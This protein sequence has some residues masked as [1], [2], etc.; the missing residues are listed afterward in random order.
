M[1]IFAS[2]VSRMMLLIFTMFVLSGVA[3]AEK[4]TPP[5]PVLNTMKQMSKFGIKVIN[6]FQG[7][8][9]LTGIVAEVSNP[10]IK[11]PGADKRIIYYI[12]PTGQYLIAGAIIDLKERRNLV[13]EASATYLEHD[14]KL[15]TA[16]ELA[17]LAYVEHQPSRNGRWIYLFVDP[18]CPHCRREVREMKNAIEKGELG[19]TGVRWVPISLGNPRATTAVSLLL[20]TTN[21][22]LEQFISLY[23]DALPSAGTLTD[24]LKT[25]AK[26]RV[27][28]AGSSALERNLNYLAKYNISGV[29]YAVTVTPDD[30]H[31]TFQGYTSPQSFF[32]P[33]ERKK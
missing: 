2:F 25:P 9:S 8:I 16:S 17:T 11:I 12:D 10:Q 6:Y 23:L 33:K 19:G 29:P 4:Y 3:V 13:A 5:Q 14:R 30:I 18:T 1:R 21:G 24:I 15:P 7:P 28:A 27:L 20:G 22:R 32:G 31:Q 26:Q